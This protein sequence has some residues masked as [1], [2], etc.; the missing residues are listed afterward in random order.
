LE[1]KINEH[2]RIIDKINIYINEFITIGLGYLNNLI[3]AIENIPK[4][5]FFS[6]LFHT[7]KELNENGTK[8]IKNNVKNF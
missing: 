7:I 8:Y 5:I 6:I 4:Q 3:K 1:N 2:I